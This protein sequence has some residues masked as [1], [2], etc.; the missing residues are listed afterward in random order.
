MQ[1]ILN[2]HRRHALALVGAV[3]LSPAFAWA[4]D[5][6]VAFIPGPKHTIAVGAID[7][8]GT[9]ATPSATNAGGPISAALITRLNASRCCRVVERDVTQTM[10][11][12]MDL[13]KSHVTAGNSA[14]MPG[15]ML[16]AQ[17]LIVGSVTAQSTADRGSGLSLGSGATALTLGHSSGDIEI[18]LRMVDTRTGALVNTFKVKHKIQSNAI[19][20]T[21]TTNGVAVGPNTFFNTPQGKATDAALEDAVEQIA[22]TLAAMP[23]RGQVVKYEAGIVWANAGAEGGVN[24]GDRFSVQRVGESLTDPATG[25]VLKENMQDLGVVT[26]TNV[27]DKIAW[28]S[29]QAAIPTDPVRGDY[30]VMQPRTQ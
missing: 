2:V 28:G 4:V 23:W 25:E 8:I 11:T 21:T 5:Q 17:F 1:T 7:L 16:P 3:A 18:D 29:Y 30:L 9:Y 14:P 15:N 26:I 20:L 10:V 19:G 22:K 6:R 27:E 12:E 24:I 13:A